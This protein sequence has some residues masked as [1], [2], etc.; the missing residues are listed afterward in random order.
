MRFLRKKSKVEQGWCAPNLGAAT[1]FLPF[2]ARLQVRTGR[3]AEAL[4]ALKAEIATAEAARRRT[5]AAL[6]RLLQAEAMMA[7]GSHAGLASDDRSDRLGGRR[8]LRPLVRR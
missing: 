6:L 5:R 2:R 8:W 7:K 4:S 1:H 3:G